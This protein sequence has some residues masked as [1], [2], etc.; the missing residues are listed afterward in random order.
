MMNY[1]EQYKAWKM[2]GIGQ[3]PIWMI[4]DENN[5]IINKNP[6]KDELKLLTTLPKE[7]YKRN[8]RQN[9][10]KNKEYL[11]R[12]MIHFYEENNRVPNAVDFTH[13]SNYHSYSTYIRIFG[14]WNNAIKEAGLWKKRYNPTHTCYRCGRSF[15]EVLGHP[16]REKDNDGKFIGWDCANCWEKYDPNSN[17]NIIKPK[18]DCRNNN[19]DPNS[20]AGIGYITTVLVKKFL[21]IEDCFDKTD[22]FNYRGYDMI[23]HKYWGKIDVK[24]SS[25]L[26]RNYNS[27]TLWHSFHTVK[28]NKP[29]FF[30][31]IGY[32][33]NR[34]HVI[35]VYIIPN[36][37]EVK[38]VQAIGVPLTEYSKWHEF[39]VSEEE[40]KKWDD[41]FH[42]MKLDNCT[43][44]RQK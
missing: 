18:A 13:N 44:L 37:E 42:T 24:G 3:K 22:N 27:N 28:N 36:N 15:D 25:L 17:T 32:D 1:Q 16:T 6:T 40:I 10:C 39:R 8:I 19:L 31:C 20:N 23:E 4:I 2:S 30:F 26:H 9:I 43:I 7:K 38:A 41:I 11:L 29:N 33:K 5:N 21:G 34:K 14:G 12:R 35:V